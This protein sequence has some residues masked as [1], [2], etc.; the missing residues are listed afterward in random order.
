ML[1]LA[2]AMIGCAEPSMDVL[3]PPPLFE[4]SIDLRADPASGLAFW[5]FN[6]IDAP[7]VQA[8]MVQQFVTAAD[9]PAGAVRLPFYFDA[10]KSRPV[11]VLVPRCAWGTSAIAA[12][13]LVYVMLGSAS[14]TVFG[15]STE[16]CRYDDGFVLV[17]EPQHVSF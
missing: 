10:V 15:T 8:V 16:T 7:I 9:A 17:G 6:A 11:T 1:V 14:G 2:T 4:Q 12:Q 3:E 13:E 5:A